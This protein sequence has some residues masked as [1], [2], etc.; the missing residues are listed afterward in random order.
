M[1]LVAIFQY[2]IVALVFMV[3]KPFKKPFYSN[4]WFT[5]SWIALMIA[6]FLLLFNPFEWEFLF[7]QEQWAA[8]YPFPQ[9]SW[10]SVIMLIILLNSVVTVIWELV[11]VGFVYNLWRTRR[12]KKK[13]RHQ[14]VENNYQPPH[15]ANITL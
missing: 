3:G 9:S 5:S 1:Y 4:I 12:E 7:D 11:V 13:V 10:R 15:L 2:C 8:E 6:N 14:S